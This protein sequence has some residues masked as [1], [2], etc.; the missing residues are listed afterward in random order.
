MDLYIDTVS[1]E[2]VVGP[3]NGTSAP[4]PRFIQGDTI[5]INIYLLERTTTFPIQTPYTIKSNATLS[6]KVALGPKDGSAGSSLYA[7]QFTWARD[8]ANTY[9]TATFALNTAAIATLLGS[10][11]SATA[12]FEI[13]YTDNLYPT[14]VLQKEVTIQAEVIE[15]AATSVPAGATAMTAEEANAIFLKRTISGVVILQNDSTG[16]QIALYVGDDGGF[17]ADPIN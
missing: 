5:T 10:A 7:S 9:F 1:G 8:A 15:T 4:L 13:E 16:K 12:W 17:H 2:S 6:L 11:A 14:T 3:A